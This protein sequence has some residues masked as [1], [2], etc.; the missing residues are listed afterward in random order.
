MVGLVKGVF[1]IFLANFGIER[2]GE[3]F[4]TILLVKLRL[5]ALADTDLQP[6]TFCYGLGDLLSLPQDQ[7][8]RLLD[9]FVEAGGN[10]FDS[11]HCYS[12]WLPGGNAQSEIG[13]G[14]YVRRRGLK[15]AVTATKGGHPGAPG[16]RKVE[17]HLSPE[18]VRADI[19]DS[20]GR[21]QCDTIALYY[22]HRDDPQIPVN[23]IIGALNE[24]VRCGRIK[25]IGASNWTVARVDEANTYAREN[26][27]APFVISQPRWSLAISS[28]E[29]D[30]NA[31]GPIA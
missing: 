14:D 11:A 3:D 18:R 22:L 27:L 7:S 2:D 15:D 10:F 31:P 28:S 26:G 8:D 23:E 19:D 25:Y 5:R 16:Y 6:S 13:I 20:L 12:F 9:A 30:L 4:A 21:L 17:K 1:K 24:E 29:Y